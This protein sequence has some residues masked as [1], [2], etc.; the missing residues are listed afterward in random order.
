MGWMYAWRWDGDLVAFVR[1]DEPGGRRIAT[2]LPDLPS[3][4]AITAAAARLR[5]T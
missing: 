3:A 2:S 4:Q 1:D 5:G